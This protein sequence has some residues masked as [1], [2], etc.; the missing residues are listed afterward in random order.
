MNI[1]FIS[2]SC[3]FKKGKGIVSKSNLD[4]LN[5][6]FG[7]ENVTVIALKGITGSNDF[8]KYQ[9]KCYPYQGYISKYQSLFNL[10]TM[11]H[12]HLS[13][14]IEKDV[15][16][17][18]LE[19]DLVFIDDSNFGRL[20][21]FCFDNKI[22][23]ICFFHNI[24]R[25]LVIKW[26]RHYGV[27]LLPSCF[28]TIYNENL[29]AKYSDISMVLNYR[30]S[31]LYKK[32]YNKEPE[33]VLPVQIKENKEIKIE[34][35]EI[36]YDLLFV[37]ADYY[38][39]V[40]GLRWFV[41]NVLNDLPELIL[42]VVGFGMEKYREEFKSIKNLK[43]IGTV[44]D[45]SH[46]YL[47]SKIVISPIFEGGGMKVKVAEAFMYGSYIIGTTESATG[48]NKLEDFIVCDDAN[49]F[50]VN[51][52]NIIKKA[53]KNNYFSLINR[54]EYKSMHNFKSKI[55]DIRKLL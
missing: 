10:I 19:S 25:D 42:T 13:S 31:I 20:N 44:D 9:N 28:A 52:L 4:I 50:K 11:R 27:K 7:V 26:F 36:I 23:S 2:D 45:L 5:E 24:R 34:K 38:P 22:K 29:A 3:D 6:I 46:Y 40:E 32:F 15:K 43:I 37:G 48:Y 53:E 18:I 21:K 33:F 17:K 16:V 30:D 54:E 55:N 35:K 39:N 49:H 47:S 8:D 12:N 14:M 51:I 41:A 1:L